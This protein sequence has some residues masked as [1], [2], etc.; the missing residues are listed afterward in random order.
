[1]IQTLKNP[2][3]ILPSNYLKKTEVVTTLCRYLATNIKPTVLYI[4]MVKWNRSGVVLVSDFSSL[5][6]KP[7]KIP[8]YKIIPYLF[9]SY[10]LSSWFN[11]QDGIVLTIVPPQTITTFEKGQISASTSPVLEHQ[12]MGRFSHEWINSKLSGINNL[13]IFILKSWYSQ[14]SNK[15]Q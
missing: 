15:S 14:L 12:I 9:G 3:I 10:A 6:K 4:G 5:I 8:L 1:M 2:S 7:F 11:T 13:E